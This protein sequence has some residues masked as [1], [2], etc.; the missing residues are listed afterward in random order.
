M[1]AYYSFYEIIEDVKTDIGFSNMTNLYSQIRQ[2]I[3]RAEEEINPFSGY[4]VR[5]RMAYFKGNGNFDGK[6]IKLPQDFVKLNEN[7]MCQD[8]LCPDKII[9]TNSHIVICGESRDSVFF[10]Y[11]GLNCDGE[12]NPVV[13]RNH[14]EA[15]V[16]FI[17]WKLYGSKVFNGDG[18]A[19]LRREYKTEWEDSCMAARGFDLF[20]SIGTLQKMH[21]IN[22]MTT[23]QMNQKLCADYSTTYLCD[24]DYDESVK[25]E[26]ITVFQLDAIGATENPEDFTEKFLSKF[27]SYKKTDFISGI[28]ISFANIGKYGF[29]IDNAFPGTIDIYDILGNHINSSMNEYYNHESKKLIFVSK[30]FISHSSIYFKITANA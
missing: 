2:L 11:W 6:N 19:Q 14:K 30:D 5:K 17:V 21:N 24:N 27:I 7:M 28:N 1:N 18:S 20:P 22:S 26:K 13:A 25:N 12:G 10:S 15:V 16:N 9:Q 29:A 4:L 8:G 3:A 23:A